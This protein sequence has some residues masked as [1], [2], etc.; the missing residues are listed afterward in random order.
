MQLAEI[1]RAQG[2]P[3][4]ALAVLE[5]VREGS[6]VASLGWRRVV[7]LRELGRG[8]EA[9]ADLQAARDLLAEDLLYGG[10]NLLAVLVERAVQVAPVDPARAAALLGCVAAHRGA[11]VL[12]W[13]MDREIPPLEEQLLPAYATDYEAGRAMDPRTAW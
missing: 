2:R 1:Y 12:P 11:W 7:C 13:W 4:E 10:L 5:P 9:G 6:S 8:S 3:E